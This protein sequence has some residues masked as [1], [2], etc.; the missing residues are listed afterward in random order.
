MAVSTKQQQLDK[1]GLLVDGAIL[2]MEYQKSARHGM[3]QR[4]DIIFHIPVEHSN[5]VVSANNYA[6]W[7]LK[8]RA[9][10][11]DALADFDKLNQMFNYLHYPIGFFI[12]IDTKD[13]MQHY[14]SGEYQ[15]QLFSVAVCLDNSKIETYW[16]I[17]N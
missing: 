9:S 5:A 16:G 17:N 13:P 10:I 14:Y 11:E 8:R 6:V 1:E 12:N 3:G 4:P 7:A 15:K 2:E